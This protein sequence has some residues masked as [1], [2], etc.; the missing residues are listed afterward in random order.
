MNQPDVKRI[1]LV[2]DE[3]FTLDLLKLALPVAHYQLDYVNSATEALSAVFD[4]QPDV[5]LLDVVMPG[6]SGLD[7]CRLIKHTPE[8][9]HIPIIMLSGLD[10]QADVDEANA[11]G[12]C[13]YIAKPF[14]IADLQWQIESHLHYA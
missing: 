4:L 9:A 5:V 10:S 3:A 1:L 11:V 7:V 14:N 8:T 13:G 12:A 6:L 2:D